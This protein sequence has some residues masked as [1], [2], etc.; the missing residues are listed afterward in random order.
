[1]IRRLFKIHERFLQPRPSG[2]AQK[3]REQRE[4]RVA[5]IRRRDLIRGYAF[6]DALCILRA[7]V[8]VALARNLLI[9]LENRR[10]NSGHTLCI[11]TLLYTL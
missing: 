9:V 7:L 10:R 6:L 8:R 5:Q 2:A 4:Q 1:M 3:T 11:Y